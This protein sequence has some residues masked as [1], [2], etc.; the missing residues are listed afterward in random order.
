MST[1]KILN[2][3]NAPETGIKLQDFE[4]L[5]LFHDDEDLHVADD[6]L[7]EDFNPF[8]ADDARYHSINY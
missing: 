6:H 8:D 1:S 5:E 4:T 7:E 3:L 2:E